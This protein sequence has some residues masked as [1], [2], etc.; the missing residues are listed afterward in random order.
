MSLLLLHLSSAHEVVFVFCAEHRECLF[1][2]FSCL[3]ARGVVE[4]CG[5]ST[6]LD[7]PEDGLYQAISITFNCGLLHSKVILCLSKLLMIDLSFGWAVYKPDHSLILS[8]SFAAFTVVM[9]P[10]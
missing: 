3:N 2:L 6:R 7:R 10:S 4:V 8:A 1:S 9:S 5:V